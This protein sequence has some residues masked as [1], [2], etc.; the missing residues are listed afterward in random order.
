[1][2]TTFKQLRAKGWISI[3]PH[4]KQI[5]RLVGLGKTNA[6]IAVLL[7][8]KAITVKNHIAQ[9]A[10]AYGIG[11]ATRTNVRTMVVVAALVR[12]DVAIE[13]LREVYLSMMRV[14]GALPP[15]DRHGPRIKLVA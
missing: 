12:G 1:M 3:T 4:R 6:D 8:M 15:D 9:I 10:K 11:S 7:S 5:I 2:T 13:E 14:S